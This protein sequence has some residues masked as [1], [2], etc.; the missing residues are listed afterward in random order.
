MTSAADARL[1][2]CACAVPVAHPRQQERLEALLATPQDWRLVL[3]EA[4]HHA[5]SPLV[6]RALGR[7]DRVPSSIRGEL[8]GRAM[9][10]RVDAKAYERGLV[11]VLEVAD[12]LGLDVLLLKGAALA[13]QIYP[14]PALRPM[15]DL[16]LLVDAERARELQ[17][18]LVARGFRRNEARRDDHHHLEQLKRWVDGRWVAVEVHT[19]VQRLWTETL[20]DVR[21]QTVPVAVGGGQALALGPVPMLR[22]LHLHG[23]GLPIWRERMRYIWLADLVGALEAWQGAVDATA[24]EA[25]CPRLPGAA[26]WIDAA[27]PL[28]GALLARVGA[29]AVPAP[30]ADYRGWPRA[31]WRWVDT[32][33]PPRWWLGLRYGPRSSAGLI[34]AWGRHLHEVVATAWPW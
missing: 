29:H 28:S 15:R 10:A 18:A 24:L 14:D 19:L 11:E 26:A 17:A 21:D 27:A 25:A 32:V 7:D 23:F 2:L 34:G 20:E 4:H 5:L 22:H 31:G 6:A 13:R 33:L 1:L 3:D 9:K 30:G 8:L 12:G 16:D